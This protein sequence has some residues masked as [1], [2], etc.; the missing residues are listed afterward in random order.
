ME[1]DK[2]TKNEEICEYL[3]GVMSE[4]REQRNSELFELSNKLKAHF[5]AKDLE[6]AIPKLEQLLFNSEF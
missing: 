5:G 1:I 2:S 3:Q 6:E 4:L